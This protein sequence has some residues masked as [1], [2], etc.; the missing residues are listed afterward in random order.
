MRFA[1]NPLQWLAT[2]DGWLDF[3]AALPLPR[4]VD[5]VAQLGF[6]AL[7]AAPPADMALVEYAELLR[8][9]GVSPAP[10][11]FSAPLDDAG[12]R[13]ET[14]ARA[15]TLAGQHAELGL[16][17]MFIA[18]AMAPTAPRVARPAVGAERDAERLKRIAE[19]LELIGAET[20]RHGV[21]ACLH[22]HVGTWI[23]AEDELE[24]L[25]DNVDAQ[26]LALG[27]DTGHLAWA[28]VDPT[29]FLARHAGRVKA[30]HVKDI[31]REVAA[32]Y[33]DSGASY[34][35]V[36]AAGLWAEPGFGDLPFEAIF[37]ALGHSFAGWAIIEV[38]RPSL[39]SPEESVRAC[40]KWA[41]A[42]ASRLPSIG[43]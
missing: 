16:T 11:Y 13:D 43:L 4:L 42:R 8:S 10:G 33:R 27:P 14:I 2:A 36:V 25:L 32:R 24:W 17:E 22:Q 23:E 37:G 7:M 12:R 34:H 38:D 6:S 1:I 20:R 15:G 40:A 31:R 3:G 35:G 18:A 21:T 39:P 28:E 5:T 19:T 9:H 41:Q 29:A 26:V 30:V